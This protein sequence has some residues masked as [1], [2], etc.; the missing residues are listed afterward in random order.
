MKEKI[1]LSEEIASATE[2]IE[3]SRFIGQVKGVKDEADATNFIASVRKK[4]YDA[5][6]NCYAY[7]VCGIK[8]YSDDGE[9]QGTAGMPILS[10]I[11]NKGLNDVCV[12]VTRYFGGIKLGAGGLVRAYNK[13][14][15]RCIDC[16][17]RI[18]YRLCT[19]FT[20]ITSYNQ[21]KTVNLLCERYGKT[22][23]IT[24]DAEITLAVTV[25]TDHADAFEKNLTESTFGRCV[26]TR[27]AEM[28]LPYDE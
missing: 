11:E 19:R 3:R 13:T 12:V 16:A 4:Y 9:P 8:R 6:H 17:Q 1:T 2:V 21:F 23:K 26:V 15:S 14:A 24:Y 7:T 28:L 18:I 5:T 25:L 22:D 27:E 10:C 20:I